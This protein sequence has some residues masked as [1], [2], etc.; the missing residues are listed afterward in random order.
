MFFHYSQ[1]GDEQQQQ[2]RRDDPRAPRQLVSPGDE[3]EFSVFTAPRVGKL[4]ARGVKA[5]PKGTVV[6]ELALRPAD[7]GAGAGEGAGEGGG[8]ADAKAA[9]RFTGCVLAAASESR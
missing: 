9:V 5:L 6:F 8:G 7:A 2:Q 4:S 3:V 1:L